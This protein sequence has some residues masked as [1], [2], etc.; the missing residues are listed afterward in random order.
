MNFIGIRVHEVSKINI[1]GTCCHLK[2]AARAGW[3]YLK[4]S[5]GV[6]S[7]IITIRYNMG[8]TLIRKQ[9]LLYCGMTT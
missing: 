2:V 3:C 6:R 8:S 4:K 7:Q 9:R 5:S 1:T